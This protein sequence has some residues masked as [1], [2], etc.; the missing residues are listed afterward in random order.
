MCFFSIQESLP[1]FRIS[2]NLALRKVKNVK[3]LNPNTKWWMRFARSLGFLGSLGSLGSLGLLEQSNGHTGIWILTFDI[4]Q[5]QCG[6]GSVA[7]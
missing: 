7:D 2:P 4:R 5:F 3:F 6:V 1:F